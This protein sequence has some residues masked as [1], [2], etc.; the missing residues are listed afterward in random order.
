V[1]AAC[2]KTA[3]AVWAADGGQHEGNFVRLLRPDTCEVPEQR[4]WFHA[5][6]GHGGKTT[7][8]GEHGAD[9]R[10]PDTKLGERVG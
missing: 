10:V 7:D 5:G 3:R 8:Q 1:N 9:G 2:G 4:R 6:G